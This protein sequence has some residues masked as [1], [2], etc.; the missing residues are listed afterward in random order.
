MRRSLYTHIIAI[1]VVIVTVVLAVSQAVDSHLTARA[2]RQDVKE[3]AELVLRTVTLLWTT[4]AP[5]D[6]KGKLAAIVS[7][8]REVDAIDIL[9][10]DGNGS[11][12]ELSTRADGEQAGVALAGEEVRQL[13]RHASVTRPLPE[14]QGSNGWRVTVPLE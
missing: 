5:A 11:R 10:L 13:E 12:V 4:T 9:R 2:V 3:R 7:G 8:D 1:V 14:P 6:L